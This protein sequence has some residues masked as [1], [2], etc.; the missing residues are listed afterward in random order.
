MQEK[1]ETKFNPWVGKI[2]GEGNGDPRAVLHGVLELDMTQRLN[3]N[4]AKACGPQHD[5]LHPVISALKDLV[6]AVQSLS[7][8]RLFATP[9]TAAHQASL[10]FTISRNLLKL[11]LI[12]S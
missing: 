6:A 11:M 4:Y 9:R 2:P 12:E 10:S 8:V 3:D 5:L 1:Q 7:R